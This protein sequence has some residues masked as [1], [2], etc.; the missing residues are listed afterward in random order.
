MSVRE[1]IKKLSDLPMDASVEIEVLT[2]WG[3]DWSSTD[4]I[5]VVEL[6]ESRIVISQ[7]GIYTQTVNLQYGV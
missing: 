1:L 3:A 4:D 5:E 2:D 6:H 7:T